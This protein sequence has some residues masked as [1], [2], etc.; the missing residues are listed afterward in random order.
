MSSINKKKK[1]KLL[2]ENLLVKKPGFRIFGIQSS[3]E[4]YP[5]A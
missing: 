2:D 3:Y 4:Q 1:T 5:S